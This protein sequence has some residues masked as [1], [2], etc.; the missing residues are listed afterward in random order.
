MNGVG[1]V[2]QLNSQKSALLPKIFNGPPRRCS[3]E[4]TVAAVYVGASF[5]QQLDHLAMAVKGRIMEGRSA[6]LVSYVSEPAICFENSL[7]TF[8]VA[9]LRGLYQVVWRTHE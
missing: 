9:L 2:V 8:Q 4:L 5:Q 7:D 3:T 1:K 6:S